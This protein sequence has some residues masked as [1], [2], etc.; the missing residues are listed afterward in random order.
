MRHI[1]SL[2]RATLGTL[3][4]APLFA[5]LAAT[6]QTIVVTADGDPVQ[7]C[8]EPAALYLLPITCGEGAIAW[9]GA[10]HPYATVAR[11]DYLPAMPCPVSEVSVAY[12]DGC[13]T[14]HAPGRLRDML[15]VS[16]SHSDCVDVTV[17]PAC[18][19]EITF[20][21]SGEGSS[22]ALHGNYKTTVVLDGVRLDNTHEQPAL[23]IDNGKRID[24]IA[25]DGTRN[26]FAD[27]AG[28]ER[29]SAFYVKGHA[30]WKGAGDVTVTGR[31][32]HAYSSNE[33]TLFK[34]SFTGTFT[35]PSAA[36]DGLHIE[37]YLQIGGGTFTVSGTSGDA[38][39]VAYVYDDD[40]VTI[41]KEELNGQFLMRGG[42]L[43][44]TLAADD[45]KGVKTDDRLTV[46]AGNIRVAA[47]ADGT[48]GLSAGTD[49][50][51]GTEGG[52]TA[53]ATVTLLATGGDYEVILPDGTVDTDK[54]RGLKVKRDF[55]H[56]PSTLIRDA[57]STITRKKIVDVD[58]TYRPLG[59]TLSGIT[60]E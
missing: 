33:Y 60:I 3:L 55:Y 54:C 35:V 7:W 18:E 45:T 16:V 23:W 57:A 28:N 8:Y 26:H 32:R 31:A 42:S 13:A 10:S 4:A 20:R 30:E 25:A 2:L 46:E 24:I 50:I 14:I 53:D 37:Q 48:R 56:Y 29:K 5:P 15:T 43:D 49:F 47:L 41:A 21:L 11:I 39:D 44:L 12:S 59:G 38:I 1:V 17:A 51:L 22:F 34:P 27:A 40:G 6:A 58:G 9:E 19:E 36:G 52:Q